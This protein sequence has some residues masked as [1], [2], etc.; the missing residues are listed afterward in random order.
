MDW[1]QEAAVATDAPSID[2]LWEESG[3]LEDVLR[4]RYDMWIDVF[5]ILLR[6][7][8]YEVGVHLPAGGGVQQKEFHS[9]DEAEVWVD[10]ILGGMLDA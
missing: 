5:P 4:D 2:W 6:G 8:D 1:E 3:K 9:F 10:E 7:G